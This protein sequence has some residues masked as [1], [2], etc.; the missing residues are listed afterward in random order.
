MLITARSNA[1]PAADPHDSV[2]RA[3]V[4]HAWSADL[5]Q[6]E[7]RP[8]L[9]AP[10]TGFGQLEVLQTAEIDGRQ[11]LL[12]NCLAGEMTPQAR[13]SAPTGGVW[14]TEIASPLGPYDIG[15]AQLLTDDRWYVGKFIDDRETGESKFMAFVNVVD[16]EFVGAISDPV[17]ASWEGDRLVLGSPRIAAPAVLCGHAPG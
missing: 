10:G 15:G 2:D 1:G 8:P 16:G 11:V 12:F 9:S 17:V 3:V 7:P 14:V 4:G 6:W 13:A 5:E